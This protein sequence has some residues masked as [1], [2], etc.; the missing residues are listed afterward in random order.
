MHLR[1]LATAAGGSVLQRGGGRWSGSSLSSNASGMCFPADR[2]NSYRVEVTIGR[3]PTGLWRAPPAACS[4]A[5]GV[6]IGLSLPGGAPVAS[7]F[8]SGPQ[9]PIRQGG[10]NVSGRGRDKAPRAVDVSGKPRAGSRRLGRRTY[11]TSMASRGHEAHA[12]GTTVG[13]R[14]YRVS[15]TAGCTFLPQRRV[16]R[17]VMQPQGGRRPPAGRRVR[18]LP[19]EHQA[20]LRDPLRRSCRRAG[21]RGASTPSRC[22]RTT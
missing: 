7:P 9:V 11:V 20:R 18:R 5:G 14:W 1:E 8:R 17:P 12:H 6:V 3:C 10:S 16:G 13:H 4:E 22:S 21:I 19:G 2:S 15:R